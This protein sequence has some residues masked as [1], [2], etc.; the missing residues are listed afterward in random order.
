MSSAAGMARR[1]CP[2]RRP[3]AHLVVPAAGVRRRGPRPHRRPR[4]SRRWRGV[5]AAGRRLRRVVRRLLRRL[6]PRQAEGRPADGGRPHLRV[7]RPAGEGGADRRAVRQ[8]TVIAHRERRRPRPALVPGRHGQRPP[9][10]LGRSHSRPG[11]SGSGLPP[12]RRHLEPLA[13]L[14]QGRVRRPQ[15]RPCLEPGVRR[16]QHRGPALRGHRQRDRPG[17]AVHAG[18]WHPHR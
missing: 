16:L 10:H 11:A 15:P 2:R 8:A 5:S 13:G 18:L 3:Q 6:H 4:P 7:G 9:R 14:H 17:A 1:R 12:V